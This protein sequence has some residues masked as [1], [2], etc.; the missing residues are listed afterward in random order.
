MRN[1]ETCY[2]KLL[3]KGWGV[4]LTVLQRVTLEN[5]EK[6]MVFYLPAWNHKGQDMLGSLPNNSLKAESLDQKY[7]AN[8]KDWCFFNLSN[9]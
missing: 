5:V 9:N 8:G 6:W 3:I 2:V 1:I 4:L 7:K